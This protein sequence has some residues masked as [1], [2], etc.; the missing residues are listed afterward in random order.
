M[1]RIDGRSKESLRQIKIKRNFLRYAEGSCLI[2][3]GNTKIVVAASVESRVPFFLRGSGTGWVTAEYGMLP[4]S[5]Q[6]RLVRDKVS[7]RTMEIQ[8]LIG[9]SLRNVVAMDKIGERTVRVDCDVIEA[10]G[11]T[12]TA[13]IVGGFIA[14]VDCFQRL[15][16][17]G[18]IN[19]MPIEDLLGAISVGIV[20]G[21]Y[22]LDLNYAEDSQASVDMNVVMR[23]NGKFIE[24]QGTAEG[25]SFSKQDLDELTQLA[26]VGIEDIIDTQRSMFKDILPNL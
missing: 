25:K 23:A 13:S 22:L 1:K 9:R 3:F 20:N 12:R 14:L 5:T 6:N 26:Q 11:G 18:V 4:R 24:L 10:D 16:N 21:D 17:E 7:G 19:S 2:K 8:R 15:K